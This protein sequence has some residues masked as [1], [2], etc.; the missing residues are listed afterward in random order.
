MEGFYEQFPIE[1]NEIRLV[2]IQPAENESATIQCR[3]I[4]T[5]YFATDYEALSYEWGQPNTSSQILVGS[6]PYPIPQN[7]HKALRSLRFEHRERTIWIDAIC[8]NQSAIRERNHQVSIL[9]DIFQHASRVCIWLGEKDASFSLVLRF[10]KELEQVRDFDSIARDSRFGKEWRAVLRL[11]SLPWFSRIWIVQE[12]SFAQRATIWC[13]DESIDWQQLELLLTLLIHKSRIVPECKSFADLNA[14]KLVSTV[15]QV[16]RRNDIGEIQGPQLSLE[17]LVTKLCKFRF[18]DKRDQIYALLGLANDIG[19][20][21][22]AGQSFEHDLEPKSIRSGIEK[23]SG[24]RLPIRSQST[25]GL[26]LESL[27]SNE[28]KSTSLQSDSGSIQNEDIYLNDQVNIDIDYSKPILQLYDQFIRFVITSSGSIDIIFRPWAPRQPD[29]PTWICVQADFSPTP[30]HMSSP[31]TIPMKADPFVSPAW[32]SPTYN[33]S[34][35]RKVWKGWGTFG[36]GFGNSERTIRIKGVVVDTISAVAT[37]A[38]NGKMPTEWL[39][40]SDKVRIEAYDQLYKVLVADRGPDGKVCPP[41][42]R[43]AFRSTLQELRG[44]NF[45][46][47]GKIQFDEPGSIKS[48]FWCRAQ[49]VIWNRSL[50]TTTNGRMG[51]VSWY[52][53]EGDRKLN[54]KSRVISG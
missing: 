53:K 42:Y 12:I 16:F 36:K 23:A 24:Q 7:L 13:G 50:I 5:K 17:I 45:I 28:H 51:M 3:I 35:G 14:V 34:G 20:W 29:L 22:S 32:Q 4:S 39:N 38:W 37:A 49:A 44:S 52:A 15:N 25:L 26:L 54:L 40:F 33:A 8:I 30:L 19:V 41:Y 10:I 46:D 6:R 2:I 11:I 1:K 43:D 31:R 9:S 18:W 47:A 21:Q 27:R 48:E